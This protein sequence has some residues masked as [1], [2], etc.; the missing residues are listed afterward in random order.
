MRFSRVPYGRISCA[1][2]TC[3]R[4]DEHMSMAP[5]P[6]R[7]R[8]ASQPVA[9]TSVKR[10]RGTFRSGT[11]GNGGD[12]PPSESRGRQCRTEDEARAGRGQRGTRA[13]HA[14]NG[15][16]PAPA[17]RVLSVRAPRGTPRGVRQRGAVPRRAADVIPATRRLPGRSGP[18]GRSPLRSV[19]L[20]LTTPRDGFGL[21]LAA[22]HPSSCARFRFRFRFRY[23]LAATGALQRQSGRF[24][25]PSPLIIYYYFLI[26]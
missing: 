25:G 23:D 13:Y 11:G 10:T 16:A 21:V 12:R 26:I 15:D 14:G 8:G 3:L 5:P 4:S 17:P 24:S 20:Y 9:T 7:E 19:A 22:R 18:A 6:C 2:V 1:P